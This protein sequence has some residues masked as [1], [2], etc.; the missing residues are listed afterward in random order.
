MTRNPYRDRE[1]PDGVL[2]G[3]VARCHR[4]HMVAQNHCRFEGHPVPVQ[5]VLWSYSRNRHPWV[6]RARR[7]ADRVRGWVP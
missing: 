3:T 4:D 6:Y 7:I 2:S 1:M 5:A